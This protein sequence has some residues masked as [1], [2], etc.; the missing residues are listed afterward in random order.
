ML[1]RSYLERNRHGG[2]TLSESQS[3]A[4]NKHIRVQDVH[5]RQAAVTLPEISPTYT[6]IIFHFSMSDVRRRTAF[7][8]RYTFLRI[9]SHWHG[10]LE[11]LDHTHQNLKCCSPSS[12]SR[13]T[14][15]CSLS[16]STH[17]HAPSENSLSVCLSLSPA[18]PSPAMPSPPSHLHPRPHSLRQSPSPPGLAVGDMPKSP[19]TT[20]KTKSPRLT[21]AH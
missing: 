16:L 4:T 12:A 3:G 18:Q 7:Q 8:P 13:S 17:T 19:T 21:T 11:T 9:A 10:C 14:R 15:L 1:I 2:E 5:D 20:T 6:S